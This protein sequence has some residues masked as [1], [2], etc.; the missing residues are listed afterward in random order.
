MSNEA[1]TLI[2]IGVVTLVIVIGAAIAFGGSS[3]P[4]KAAPKL[5]EAQ[6]KNLIKPNSHVAAVKD[7]K[8]TLVEFGDYQCPA[9]GA[10]YPIVGQI[11]DTYESKITFVFRNYPL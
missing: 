6:Q 3:S 2:G 5:S 10:S 7:A 9:C 11:L 4:D 8:I 1:K